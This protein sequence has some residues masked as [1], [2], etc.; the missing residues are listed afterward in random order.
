ML[1]FCDRWQTENIHSFCPKAEA[2]DDFLAYTTKF[3]ERTVWSDGCRSWYKSTSGG[4]DAAQDESV[5]LWPGSGLHYMEA[6]SDVRADDWDIKYTGNRFNWLGTGFSQTEL[7]KTS[8]LAYYIRETD[9]GPYLSRGKRRRVLTKSGMVDREETHAF[10][11][12]VPE[13]GRE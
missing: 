7:D 10:A 5:H 13:S 2:V 9:D 8:D 1:K 12:S 3:I 6:I 11:T 4:A